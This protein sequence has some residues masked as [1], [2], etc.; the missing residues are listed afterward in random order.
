MQLDTTSQNRLNIETDKVLFNS[1]ISHA[2]LNSDWLVTAE[3]LDDH[4]HTVESR[5]KF[6][7]FEESKQEYTLNTQIEL[8]HENGVRSLEFS[9][10]HSIDNLLCASC[11][12]FDVKIWALED[13]VNFKSKFFFITKTK[14]LNFN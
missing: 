1:Y 8:P 2:S 12:E 14:S 6:W 10:P 7:A 9:S 11:G 4:E 3:I 13:S 5:L